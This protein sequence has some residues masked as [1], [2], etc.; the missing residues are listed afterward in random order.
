VVRDAS[1]FRA[2]EN[3]VDYKGVQFADQVRPQVRQVL[4]FVEKLSPCDT[5]RPDG[6]SK[7]AGGPGLKQIRAAHHVFPDKRSKGTFLVIRTKPS[8]NGASV[9]RSG[10]R[11]YQYTLPC[12]PDKMEQLLKDIQGWHK[13]V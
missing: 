11:R 9:E 10:Y 6:R 12:G 13:E 4:D 7:K 3:M 1:S 2:N 5:Y 8:D